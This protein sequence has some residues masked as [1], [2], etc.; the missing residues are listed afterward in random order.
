MSA[1]RREAVVADLQER[2]RQL[3]RELARVEREIVRAERLI[4][5]A[6]K[7]LLRLVESPRQAA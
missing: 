1:A 4:H 3:E 6:E 7:R 5:A 2:R